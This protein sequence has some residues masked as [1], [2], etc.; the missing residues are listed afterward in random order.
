MMVKV[1][2]LGQVPARYLGIGNGNKSGT[3]HFEFVGFVLW[4][5]MNFSVGNMT[6]QCEKG[7]HFPVLL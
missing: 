5:Q 1:A 6:L 4:A 3:H 7:G 2:G